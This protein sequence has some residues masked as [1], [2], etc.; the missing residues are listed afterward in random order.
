MFFFSALFILYSYEDT[1]YFFLV[2]LFLI[3]QFLPDLVLFSFT[4][5]FRAPVYC[6]A[7]FLII[8]AILSKVS[9]FIPKTNTSL[10]GNLK[11][12]LIMAGFLMI[13]LF[14]TH[15]I[16]FNWR[17]LLLQDI[18]T[19]RDI[20]RETS[21]AYTGYVSNWLSSVVLPII[22]LISLKKKWY[23]YT[24]I[25]GTSILYLFMLGGSKAFLF[26]F[27]VII[28]FY[29]FRKSYTY[30]L[31]M[32]LL[33]VLGLL[34]IGDIIDHYFDFYFFNSLFSLRS[35]FTP[36]LIKQFYFEFFQYRPQL[37]SY[38]IFSS[39]VSFDFSLSIESLIGGT[40]YGSYLDNSNTGFIGNAYANFGYVGVVLYSVFVVV[41]FRFFSSLSIAPYF[42]GV[43][44]ILTLILQNGSLTTAF[45]SNGLIVLII[46]S[47]LVLNRTDEK[48]SLLI[49]ER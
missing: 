31:M 38:S 29:V 41:L 11:R 20:L 49:K 3:F 22:L 42:S 21:N 32:F 43:F 24:V 1:L 46:I 25:S 37:L 18:Y 17:L 16:N 35:F 44:V 48:V 6:G 28:F 39:F 8:C 4:P 12:L 10:E 26:S 9:F 2:F 7:L 27:L 15:G 34:L 5:S 45:L 33:F 13:P 47:C 14:F 40:F 19:Q 23:L 30:Q 36:A